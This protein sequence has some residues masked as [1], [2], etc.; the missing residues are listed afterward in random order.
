MRNK[1][2]LSGGLNSVLSFELLIGGRRIVEFISYLRVLV[3]CEMH[4][5]SSRKYIYIIYIYIYII[6]YNIYIIYIYIIYIIL[7]FKKIEIIC[8]V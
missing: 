7:C 6:I 2:I 5:A 1:V 4:K 8:D 3:L